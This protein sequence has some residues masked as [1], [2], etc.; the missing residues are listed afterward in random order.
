MKKKNDRGINNFVLRFANVNGTGSASANSLVAKT[1]FRMG[2]PLGAKNMFPSNIQGLPTWYEIRVS[3]KGY[4]ARRGGV[5]LLIAMNPQTYAED[6]KDVTE[7]GFLVFDSSKTKD[8]NLE[9][10]GVHFLG[11]PLAEIAMTH[12][13]GDR[14]RAL[15]KNVM[16]VGAIGY[17]LGLDEKIISD[18]LTADFGKKP[19][20]LEANLKAYNLGFNYAK[21]H[22]PEKFSFVLEK[23]NKNHDMIFMD[24]NTAAALGCLY[25]G[26]T[27]A[28]WYPITPSTS[29]VDA[30]SGFC[31]KYRKNSDGTKKFAILQAEDELAAIG[32]VLGATWNGARAFTATSGP[33]IS[34]MTEFLGYAYYAEIPA[35]IFDVQR[36]GPSTGMPTRTQQSDLLQCAFASHGDTEHILLFP[37]DPHEAFEFSITA[38]DMAE[39]FQTP[40]IIMSD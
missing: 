13:T 38:F 5:D 24:G 23:R 34:L 1:I 3:E 36:V 28:A 32:M 33:G 30:F 10:K 6:V 12:F 40:V 39:R 37:N 17:W 18:L 19:E 35:V 7:N 2:I 4:S 29:L 9:K 22:Y 21:E 31:H 16:Y 11:I 20:L 25:A 14:Q 15:L 26:A 27:V 8:R